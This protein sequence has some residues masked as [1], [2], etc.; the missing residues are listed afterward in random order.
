MSTIL[1][2]DLDIAGL[3]LSRGVNRPASDEHLGRRDGPDPLQIRLDPP[4]GHGEDIVPPEPGEADQ[5]VCPSLP[6]RQLLVR[7]LGRDRL[8]DHRDGKDARVQKDRR[9][10]HRIAVHGGWRDEPPRPPS[11]ANAARRDLIEQ[12]PV[13]FAERCCAVVHKAD[14]LRTTVGP[15]AMADRC[16]ECGGVVLA[17][18]RGATSRLQGPGIDQDLVHRDR[19]VPRILRHCASPHVAHPR[20]DL[21]Q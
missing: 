17:S 7:P 5:M 6:V 20:W 4:R 10:P 1:E 12:Q 19:Q 9:E 14:E 16:Q 11:G 15:R 3:R 8:A 21:S 18:V 13:V 2:G